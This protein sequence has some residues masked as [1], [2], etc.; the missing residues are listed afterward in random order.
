MLRKVVAESSVLEYHTASSKNGRTFRVVRLKCT[1]EALAHLVGVKLH[2]LRRAYS[3]RGHLQ[4]ALE[5]GVRLGLFHL[6]DGKLQSG[7]APEDAPESLFETE[8]AG[9]KTVGKAPPLPPA[10]LVPLTPEDFRVL[11]LLEDIEQDRINFGLYETYTPY[12]ELQALARAHGIGEVALRSALEKLE[13]HRWLLQLKKGVYRS[14]ISEIVRLLKHV[15]QRFSANDSHKRPYLIQSVRVRFQDRERLKRDVPAEAAFER[16]AGMNQGISYLADAIPIVREGFSRAVGKPS[17][18][19]FLTG[20]QKRALES[21]SKAYLEQHGSTYVITGNTGSGKTEAMLLPLLVGILREK[22]D[23]DPPGG[24]R[25]MLVYPRQA[26]A[27]NQL[28]RVARYLAAINQEQAARPYVQPRPLSLGIVFGDTPLDD[29]ELKGY[30]PGTTRSWKTRDGGHVLPYFKSEDGQD[31]VLQDLNRGRGTL[32]SPDGWRLEGFKA[33]REAIRSDPPDILVITTEMLHRW[34]LDPDYLPV[35]GL[36]VDADGSP[37][38]VPP[39]ALVFDEIHLYDGIHGAQIGMLLRR[40]RNRL[41]QAMQTEREH[42]SGSGWKYPLL[43]GMSATIGDPGAFWRELAGAPQVSEIVP[44]GHELETAQ[45]REYFLF[46]RPETFS[47][48]TAVGDASAAI[49]TIMT[50]AHNMVR[51]GPAGD[52]PA[53]FRSLVF[54]DSVG[55]VKKLALEFTD[56]ES[57]RFLSGLRLEPPSEAPLQSKAFQDGEY[58]YFDAEDPFQY[59]AGRRR[60]GTRPSSLTSKPVPVFSGSGPNVADLLEQDVIFAT[61]S[62]EVG[63]DD[64]TIQFVLQHHA[65]GNPASFVQKK[66]RAGRSLNDRPIVAVTLSRHSFRDSFYY[67]N[68]HLLYDPS[69]YRPPLNVDNYYVQRFQAVAAILDELTRLTGRN[70]LRVSA[71]GLQAHLHELRSVLERHARPISRMYTSGHIVGEAFRRVYGDWGK[72]WEWFEHCLSDPE[73]EQAA[74]QGANLFEI[75][76]EIPNNLF[77]T[78][79]LPTVRVMYPN[80]RA[81]KGEDDWQS[82]EEDIALALRELA[83]GKVSRRYGR[84]FTLLWRA[85]SSKSLGKDRVALER[86][87]SE[88]RPRPGPFNPAL[89]QP[90]SHFVDDQERWK[91]YLPL[92]LKWL[93]DLELPTRFYRVRYLEMWTFGSVNPN[94][95][96]RPQNDWHWYG[97]Y[98]PDGSVRLIFRTDPAKLPEGYRHVSPDSDSY[99]LSF[100]LVRHQGPAQQPLRLPPYFPGLFDT[101]EPYYGEVNATRS[102]LEAWD[103][104]YGAEATIKLMRKI[105]NDPHA[106]TGYNLIRY[107]S[108]HD[109]K[110]LLYGYDLTTEGV[111][112]PYNPD[113][114]E[115][116]A[117]VLFEELQ[118]DGQQKRH[119]QDQFLRFILKHE[120]WPIGGV[121]NP[122]NRFDQRKA[123]D[124]ISTLRAETAA[125][126]GTWEFLEQLCS[127]KGRERLLEIARRYYPDSRTLN[128]D[129]LGRLEQTLDS[130]KVHDFLH[131]AFR[132]VRNGQEVLAFLKDTLLHSLEHAL[133]KLF[134]TEGSTRD[135]ETGSHLRLKI[136]Y[137]EVDPHSAFYLYER[138]QDGSGATRL[139]ADALTRRTVAQRLRRWWQESLSCAVGDEEAF[140]RSAL[141]R[142]REALSG[143]TAR[144]F[145]T[146]IAERPS[147]K[148]FLL[149]LYGDFLAEDSPLLGRLG[150]LL[151]AELNVFDESLRRLDLQLEL[152]NLESEL[153]ARFQRPPTPQELAGFAYTRLSDKAQAQSSP[154]PNLR[155]LLEIYQRHAA[156]MVDAAEDED[157]ELVPWLDRFLVQIE[158]LSLSTCVDACPACLAASCDHGHIEVNRHSLS[159]RYLRMAHRILTRPQSYAETALPEADEIRARARRAGGYVYIDTPRRLGDE[160]ARKLRAAGLTYVADVLDYDK[161]ILRYVFYL[162]GA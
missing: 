158:H 110:P 112:A 98:Q 92:Q 111:R 118:A 2:Q 135:E 33:T 130:R 127:P 156:E 20:V 105:P 90:L 8:M 124:L 102:Y 61:T 7:P 152:E 161:L 70:W 142:H 69:D 73:V 50:I 15:K 32:V 36:P 56:A 38:T 79:N 6:A 41:Y 84:P 39:R 53:K 76:P 123:A 107:A 5:E 59:S 22:L 86:Y 72:V 148:E 62:L 155:K 93:Y 140:L 12:A 121:E 129:F 138:N 64:S 31:V 95:P 4:K 83:P 145:S 82:A 21:I 45:G 106:R 120:T 162:E 37:K 51:R 75:V 143:F 122:I 91:S 78:L 87:K 52:E 24:C 71:K 14:R 159:R 139:F 57:N 66:G 144:F 68:P 113:V 74:T 104:Y 114:L 116:T 25:V 55:K 133:R 126:L 96:K 54:Q 154:Y 43:I 85:P 147:P 58:W 9:V 132:R 19:I 48:G 149:E 136:H 119:L 17:G 29:A 99:P 60:P 153:A 47:R 137:G 146:D 150:G 65:P 101:V 13:Q 115:R 35:F 125:T 26:L 141:R 1:P 46:I 109:R 100:S 40:L 134:I 3:E 80:G 18:D 151:T 67:Q 49:Q 94:D 42:R 44:E 103:V 81:E 157:G 30:I 160:A 128:K 108:E 10:P 23:R 63:Y 89:I 117:R 88:D 11:G 77:S 27:K 131:R 16:V 97:K 28:Q 34:L